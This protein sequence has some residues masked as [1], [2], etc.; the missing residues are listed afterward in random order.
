MKYVE[1]N[2]WM[3]KEAKYTKIIK[4]ITFIDWKYCRPKKL[5]LKTICEWTKS[6]LMEENAG[7]EVIG[8][9]KNELRRLKEQNSSIISGYIPKYKVSNVFHFK[10]SHRHLPPP[11]LIDR[12]EL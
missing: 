9:L 3:A 2:S 1:N 10:L 11:L 4:K 12:K 7:A 5:L 8:L 6:C